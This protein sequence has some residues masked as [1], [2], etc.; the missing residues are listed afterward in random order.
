[1]Q[2]KVKVCGTI[3]GRLLSK[4]ETNTVV[5]IDGERGAYRDAFIGNVWRCTD[6]YQIPIDVEPTDKVSPF[7]H[8]RV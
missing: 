2:I 3:A 5:D 8:I 7:R 6:T 4:R 1:M